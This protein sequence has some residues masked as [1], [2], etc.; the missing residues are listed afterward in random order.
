MQ[1]SAI[2]ITFKDIRAIERDFDLKSSI[3]KDMAKHIFQSYKESSFIWRFNLNGVNGN[4]P[5]LQ[6]ET[7][8]RASPLHS[9]IYP[10]NPGFSFLL[11]LLLYS[12][13]LCAFTVPIP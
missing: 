11:F 1:L 10:T 4:F 5:K 9:N 3:K 2:P 7:H 8:R 12:L 6:R 13:F